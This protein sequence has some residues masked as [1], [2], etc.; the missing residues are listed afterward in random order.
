MMSE[1]TTNLL[2]NLRDI[3]YPE[4]VSWWPLAPGWYMLALGLVLG[5]MGASYFF[6]VWR[7]ARRQK[8]KILERLTALQAVARHANSTK[9]VMELSVLL[10]QV[11]LKLGP[12]E[13]IAHLYGDEWL[14]FLDKMGNTQEFSQGVGRLLLTAPY[15]G[16]M[17]ADIGPLFQLAED[18][19]RYQM[20]GRSF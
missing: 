12:R 4:P 15:Q 5:V 14:A 9:A 16:A 20:Q 7:R 19:L 17:P 3:Q 11:A 10:K 18:W 2:Q 1:S 6:C 13:K 8:A